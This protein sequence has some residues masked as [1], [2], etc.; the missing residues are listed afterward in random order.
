MDTPQIK[1]AAPVWVWDEGAH[2]PFSEMS[3]N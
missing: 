2:E 3:E 1:R